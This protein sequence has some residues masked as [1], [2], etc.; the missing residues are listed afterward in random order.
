MLTSIAGPAA[1]LILSIGA[2]LFYFLLLTAIRVFGISQMAPLAMILGQLFFMLYYYNIMLAVFNLLPIPPLD[3]FKV[4]G[5]LLP[6]QLYF[7]LMSFERYIGLVFL[8]L[9]MFARGFLGQLLQLISVP[10]NKVIW[11]PIELIFTLIWRLSG[12]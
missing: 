1:N 4:F 11:Q 5:S 12:L 8:V 3:G 7:K 2:A 9:V 10:F 6:D